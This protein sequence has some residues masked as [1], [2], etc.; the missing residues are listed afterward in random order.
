M[1]G[2]R[3]YIDTKLQRTLFQTR[4]FNFVPSKDD[5]LVQLADLFAGTLARC[6]DPGKL[7][8]RS[9]DL[10][11][12]LAEYS[13]AI[14]TWPPRILP[15]S[16]RRGILPPHDEF[17]ELVRHHCM[18]SV[19][20]FLE[21]NAATD[22]NRGAVET[23]QYILFHTNS[24]ESEFVH[25]GQIRDHLRERGIPLDEREFSGVIGRLRDQDVIIASG[26][27]GY[28]IPTRVADLGPFLEHTSGVVVPMLGRLK[29]ARDSLRGSSLGRLDI[30]AHED[31]ATLRALLNCV[32]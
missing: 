20:T 26:P 14:E 10:L 11:K 17:D 5:P 12:L 2:F 29:R 19:A 27:H 32:D 1:T 8:P 25:G 16:Q 18:R 24:L 23:L 15:I 3:T 13:M 30:L 7:S 4:T 22:I 9:V 21:E 28:R 6:F 31:F